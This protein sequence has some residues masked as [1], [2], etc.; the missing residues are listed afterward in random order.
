[1]K[2]GIPRPALWV[3]TLLLVSG[4]DAGT[5]VLIFCRLRSCQSLLGTPIVV[6][7]GD[8][9]HLLVGVRHL[10]D[11]ARFWAAAITAST[12]TPRC[13]GPAPPRRAPRHE[14]TRPWARAIKTRE[15][16]RQMPPWHL[17]KTVGIQHFINDCSLDD[18]QI[19]AIVR[20]VDAG[21]P[22]GDPNDLPRPVVW[23]AGDRF[24]LEVRLGPPDLV[25]QS[26]PWAM[27]ADGQDAWFRPRVELNLDESIWVRAAETKP[28]LEG[29]RIV[30]HA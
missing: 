8:E 22:L 6:L 3:T 26:R 5:S 23:P 19:D 30:H 25:V 12:P 7:V 11:R 24:E 1:M 16:A 2:I 20:W 21:A 28:S 15:V 10:V 4:L 14:E 17:D 29:R 18:A 13:A 9:D 27:P